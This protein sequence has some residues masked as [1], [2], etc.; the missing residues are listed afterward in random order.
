MTFLQPVWLL[1]LLPLL[2]AWMV[3]RQSSR[4]LQVLRAVLFLL[5]VLA[6][7]RPA[8]K[9][10]S[11]NGT[12]VVLVDRSAS[13][14]TGS[15]DQQKEAIRV[16]HRAMGGEDQLGVVSFAERAFVEQPP[17]PDPLQDFDGQVGS[18]LSNLGEAIDRAL[19]LIPAD[20]PA[21]LLILSDGRWTGRDPAAM[22]TRS[23]GAGIA[24]DYRAHQRSLA[25]DIGIQQLDAPDTVTPGES[26]IVTAWIKSPV[27]RTVSYRLRQGSQFV[28][29][30]SRELEPGLNRVLF[31]DQAL[32]AGSR[33]YQLELDTGEEDPVPENNRAKLLI[34]VEG[35]RPL[36]VVSDKSESGLFDLLSRSQLDVE[37]R[38]VSDVTWDLEHL[39]NYSGVV[40]EN[41]VAQEIGNGGMHN[42]VGLVEETG[43]GLMLT[44]GENSYGPGGYYQSPLD[45]I[46]PV[47]MELREEH[48]KLSLGIVVVLDRSGSMGAPAGFGKTKMDLANLGTAN[49]YD[50]LGPN[51][52]IGVIAVDSAPHTIVNIGRKRDLAGA[53]DK[54]LKIESMGGGIFVYE[55]LKAAAAMLQ[56]SGAGTRHI[57]LFSD[58]ADSEEP[59]QYVELLGKCRDAG[60]TCSVIGLGKVTD[61]D[62]GLLKSVA[63]HGEGEIYFSDNPHNIPQIFAQDTFAV[64]RSTFVKGPTPHKFTSG[65][66]VL[67]QNMKGDPSPLG[68]YNLNYIRQG[69]D[70][71]AVTLDEYAAP[72]VASWFVG[73][74]RVLT[75]AGEADG[76][77]AG[78]FADWE[79]S[80]EFYTSL[81][82]WV[83]GERRTLP[84]NLML[85]HRVSKG[86]YRVELHLDPD[87]EADPFG[88]I[89]PGAGGPM[90][91]AVTLLKGRPGT[92]PK[93]IEG[94]MHWETADRLVYDVPLAGSDTV[95]ATVNVPG[96]SEITLS[97]TC[98]PYSEEFKPLEDGKGGEALANLA[99]MTLGKERIELAS[100][101]DELPRKAQFV[102]I[103]PWLALLAV[104]LFLAEIIE[105]RTGFL[106]GVR[107]RKVT[108][109]RQ[110][111]T[112][113]EARTGLRKRPVARPKAR[114][115]PEPRE[116][117]KPK[118][119]PAKTA[120]AAGGL[121][122][123]MKKA[124][125][126]A[127]G[128]TRR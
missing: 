52:E 80:G 123:A 49:V 89:G 37:H 91:P 93:K 33:I 62:A 44:G 109:D 4:L 41:V 72:V 114:Q 47:S 69:A 43:A 3:W 74:G 23:A 18:D 14:P 75:F 65:I 25:G 58:A 55:A 67:N 36:L 32:Q 46:L 97:P 78:D 107:E 8:L 94:E 11:R 15:L 92:P 106:S 120:P 57:I 115:A 82:R 83:S 95:L 34:G 9:L 118:P 61:P 68:G 53:R 112:T 86:S 29:T 7:A 85:D 63:R 126:Q 1:V 101:W 24:I 21:R 26:F 103:T 113:R 59:G 54:I 110:P 48:R 35:V 12:V 98:L 102:E 100:I 27:R 20:S 96:Y 77:F 99:T 79:K 22:A 81:A 31:R 40:L 50:L 51:D 10:P 127:K 13:M 45:P 28:G 30:G 16:L 87:R 121:A 105:R 17:G 73:S 125:D 19:S 84:E 60:M 5:L 124:R 128:R 66:Q 116:S 88:Q 108:V 70:L 76:E 64:A 104:L 119:K 111:A 122:A 90:A 2:A 6:L 117:P 38:Q 39:F 42:L 56:K 71:S